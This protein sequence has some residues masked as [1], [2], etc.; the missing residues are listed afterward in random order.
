[1]IKDSG[2]QYLLRKIELAESL[3]QLRR[4]WGNMAFAYQALPEIQAAKDRKKQELS[5]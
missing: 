4:I 1:M 3:D 5:K 2:I